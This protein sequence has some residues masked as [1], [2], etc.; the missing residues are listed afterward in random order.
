MLK[1]QSEGC[2]YRCWENCV[3]QLK[4]GDATE[5]LCGLFT[6]KTGIDITLLETSGLDGFS[7]PNR[8]VY[9]Y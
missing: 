2:L 3:V 9:G 8:D 5:S 6:T 1:E 4:G 7:F